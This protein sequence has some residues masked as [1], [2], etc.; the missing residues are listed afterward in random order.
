MK[1]ISLTDGN[2]GSPSQ[3][4]VSYQKLEDNSSD[5]VASVCGHISYKMSGVWQVTKTY[6]GED[7][8]FYD[9]QGAGT[10]TEAGVP[11][12]VREGVFVTVPQG[13]KYS[14]IEVKN[15]ETVVI[16]TEYEVLPVPKDV[17]ETEEA[18]Y[19]RNDAI[20]SGDGYYP[21]GYAEFEGQQQ[22]MGVECAH[23]YVYPMHYCP[24]ER[25]VSIVQQLEIDVWFEDADSSQSPTEK[26]PESPISI[27]RDAFESLFLGYSKIYGVADGNKP[28]MIIITTQELAN[29]MRIYEGVKT[30]LYDTELV[31]VD[32]IYHRYEEKKQDEAILAYL[33]EEYAKSK[34]SYVILGGDVDQIP[35]HKDSKGF[36]CDS[37]YCT[38]GK[39]VVPRFALSRFPA[40][41]K[42]EMDSQTDIAAYYDRFYNDKIRNSAVFTTYNSSVYE[43]CK[44]EIVAKVPSGNTFKITK[45]YDGKCSKNDLVAAINGG[46]GFINYRGHGSNT[47]WSSSI[48]LSVKDVPKLSVGTNTPIVLSIACSNNDLYRNECF[49]ASWIRNEKA[50]AFL[51]ASAPSFTAVNNYFDKYLW[52]AICSE[53]LTI[54]GDIYVWATIKL[55]QNNNSS[56]SNKNI[57]EYL[58]LGDATADYTADDT[59]HKQYNEGE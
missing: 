52:E 33:N 22:V 35:T 58:L 16:D 27:G 47:C 23:I 4:T 59:T 32:D 18:K 50:V 21:M 13:K 39:T 19:I 6:N 30:F 11:M 2:E 20:Y 40:R 41:N 42:A 24:K 14:H 1:W 29:S 48:G 43:Q 17:L 53:K 12:L 34:I 8:V 26:T 44:E 5:S 15:I 36:A 31:I 28:R 56:N 7:Y 45:C 37:Y 54:I 25:K 51:G 49:G 46:T 3:K 9:L 57:R 38:D 10:F 55:Y